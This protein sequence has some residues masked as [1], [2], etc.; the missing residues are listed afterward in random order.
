[1]VIDSSLRTSEAVHASVAI[2]WFRVLES[3]KSTD[4]MRYGELLANMVPSL[5]MA[6]EYSIV[7]KFS[8]EDAGPILFI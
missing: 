4:D 2:S 1:M 8:A 3:P 6:S 5:P 7:V